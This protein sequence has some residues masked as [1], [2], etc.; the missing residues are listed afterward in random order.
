[1]AGLACQ[2]GY[3]WPGVAILVVTASGIGA[4]ALSHRALAIFGIAYAGLPLLSLLLIR[5][6]KPMA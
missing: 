4:M 2:F 6:R 5:V 3:L 1:M